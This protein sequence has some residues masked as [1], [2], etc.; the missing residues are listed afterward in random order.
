M[1]RD[2][3]S[4]AL[5][6]IS[7]EYLAECEA[8]SPGLRKLPSDKENKMGHYAHPA[9]RTG[10]KILALILAA[11][12]ILAVGITA[13]AAGILQ[14][15]FSRWAGRVDLAPMTE[16]ERAENP[17][18]AEWVDEQIAIQE[19]LAQIS[20][21][22]QPTDAAVSEGDLFSVALLESYYD[23]EKI[24]MTCRLTAEDLPVTFGFDQSHPLFANRRV[25]QDMY[26]DP[27]ED[28]RS[29]VPREADREKIEELLAKDGHVGFTTHSL[30]IRDHVY[31]NGEDFG[32]GHSDPEPDGTFYIDPYYCGLGDVELPESCR[33][34]K[35]VE[36]TLRVYDGLVH[37][38][39]EG[40]SV[41]WVYDEGELYPVSFVVENNNF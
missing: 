6:G 25:H 27:S 14:S 32:Y 28:W 40:N 29:R 36:V 22:M 12:L 10:R 24:A 13:Y 4:E 26:W 2:R 16:E 11:C 33:N 9:K 15:L 39:L 7:M 8:Y 31:V 5:S 34:Q 35:Q 23:G 20:E 41:S 37:Y 1:N 30:V 17:D 38:W 19:Q 3:I 21:N 18:R